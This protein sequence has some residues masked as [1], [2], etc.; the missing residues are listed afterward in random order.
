MFGWCFGQV[1]LNY[2]ERPKQQ[3]EKESHWVDL[4][5]FRRIDK[6]IKMDTYLVK[7]N[8]KGAQREDTFRANSTN[9]A[10]QFCKERYPGCI[11]QGTKK[12]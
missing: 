12:L 9:Q 2:S 7:F 6:S 4:H 10:A 1:L 11:P 5:I 3:K 8:L